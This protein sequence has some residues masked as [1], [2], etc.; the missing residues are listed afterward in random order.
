MQKGERKRER[1]R[2]RKTKRE[3]TTG[4][5]RELRIMISDSIIDAWLPICNSR[6][7]G[8]WDRAKSVMRAYALLD[9]EWKR[10]RVRKEARRAHDVAFWFVIFTYTGARVTTRNDK[11]DCFPTFTWVLAS[12]EI[13]L[14]LAR[15]R[16]PVLQ[17]CFWWKKSTQ[18]YKMEINNSYLG[19]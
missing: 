3:W 11:R 8:C 6:F 15:L 19:F 5:E 1:E 13:Q 17:S 12:D 14:T 18:I 10:S 9:D 16:G 7:V 4:R 2:G